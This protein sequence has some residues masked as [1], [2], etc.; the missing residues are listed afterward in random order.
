MF[1]HSILVLLTLALICWLPACEPKPDPAATTAAPTATAKP[2]PSAKKPTG[3][4]LL[5]PK[6]ATLKAP[7]KYK[8]KF[9]TTKGD[10]VI[11]FIR[12]WAPRGVDRV[13][14]LLKIGFYKDIAFH[15]V[16]KDFV[17]QFG[18]SGDTEVSAAWKKAYLADEMVKQ[19]NTEWMVSFAKSGTD[20]RSTQIFINLK[21]NSEDFDKQ[22]FSP[23]GKVVDGKDVIKK[24]YSD[25]GESVMGRGGNTEIFKQGNFYLEQKWPKLDYIKTA[26]LVE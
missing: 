17:V 20:T 25:Y 8:V 5:T 6:A 4:P 18:I 15:R 11:E 13:Y 1:R 26:A 22:G 21:D 7:D 14:N 2:K 9:T 24:L 23:I 3:P 19:K 16:I 10:F 12:E